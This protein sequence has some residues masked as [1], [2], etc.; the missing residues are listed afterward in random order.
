MKK[1]AWIVLAAMLLTGCQNVKTEPSGP[2]Y[3]DPGDDEVQNLGITAD[4]GTWKWE[5]EEIRNDVAKLYKQAIQ[6]CFDEVTQQIIIEDSTSMGE[7]E[8][9]ELQNTTREDGTPI[10]DPRDYVDVVFTLFDIDMDNMPELVL[11]YGTMIDDKLIA[12]Y[13][14]DNGKLKTIVKDYDAVRSYFAAD[15]N[16]NEFVLVEGGGGGAASIGWYTIENGEFKKTKDSGEITYAEG[17]TFGDIL[18]QKGIA[19][20]DF[21]EFYGPKKTWKIYYPEGEYIME[22]PTDKNG[23]TIGFDYS[24]F[25]EMIG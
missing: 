10:Y 12:I 23:D 15:T 8:Y 13:T 25:E 21:T 19:W 11:T 14:Y 22:E 5:S 17:E 7:Q 18:K 2:E 20:I 6:D 9:A 1:T 4:F 3:S 16:T 24:Q